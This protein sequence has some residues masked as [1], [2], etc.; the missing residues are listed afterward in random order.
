[1][2]AKLSATYQTAPAPL[3]SYV[4]PTGWSGKPLPPANANA[5]AGHSRFAFQ[6][7]VATPQS[8]GFDCIDL[9]VSPPTVAHYAVDSSLLA[10]Y[11]GVLSGV[12]PA[13]LSGVVFGTRQLAQNYHATTSTDPG[14]TPLTV[15]DPGTGAQVGTLS[16]PS[17]AYAQNA[18]ITNGTWAAGSS[19]DLSFVSA[20]YVTFV[21]FYMGGSPITYKQV[22]IYRFDIAAGTLNAPVVSTNTTLLNNQPINNQFAANDQYIVYSDA[23][24]Y[25]IVIYNITTDTA[26]TVSDFDTV[27]QVSGGQFDLFT[28]IDDTF[29]LQ[30]SGSLTATDGFYL[31]NVDGTY[32]RLGDP[33]PGGDY[34]IT[35][36]WR[37][38]NYNG[39]YLVRTSTNVPNG[40]HLDIAGNVL[41]D[42]LTG[43][44]AATDATAAEWVHGLLDKLVC[45]DVADTA[46]VHALCEVMRVTGL[47]AALLVALSNLHDVPTFADIAACAFAELLRE[48]VTVTDT[49]R[50]G[51][52]RAAAIADAL[53]LVSGPG[54]VLSAQAAS[55]TALA[56]IDVAA[57]GYT[58]VAT[59]TIATADRLQHV[60]AAAMRAIDALR[61][62]DAATPSITLT[63]LV[64]ESTTLADGADAAGVFL[65]ALVDD[66][67]VLA[68]LTL[69]DGTYLAWV[70]NTE[71]HGYVKYQNYP[72]NSFAKIGNQYIGCAAD[73]LYA[74]TGDTDDGAPI[75]A[76]LRSALADFGSSRL[77]R[78]P[79][80]YLGYRSNGSMVLRVT[81]ME[82]DR[83]A[84]STREEHWY[85]L[86]PRAMN[87]L[88]TNRVKL[89]RGL[90]SVYWS[91]ELT[92]VQGADFALDE[93]SWYPVVLE[94]RLD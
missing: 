42:T 88:R 3:D 20:S 71:T 86:A 19:A 51:I 45:V 87:T 68:Q 1:M 37:P 49:P 30:F 50:A 65:D 73:G 62:G 83:M 70:V 22:E 67:Q 41:A 47:P 79:S 56:L 38:L 8:T 81:A 18:N 46:L 48:S 61:L 74:L 29:Y 28:C 35:P 9:S 23:N 14:P 57:F 64:D 58:D 55:A 10:G 75:N 5:V 4:V 60:V 82:S 32:T 25:L 6:T 34:T 26:I 77:K 36:K 33:L 44:L 92:N 53:A 31:L 2:S 69:E 17:I 43:S 93:V 7:Y 78:M 85:A 84:G 39:A 76:T 11:I 40:L 15:F 52:A 16:V 94:R 63:A 59:D 27:A 12:G 91:W 21:L 72:F 54:S 13:A 90:Q 24:S 66:A 89:G 80:A